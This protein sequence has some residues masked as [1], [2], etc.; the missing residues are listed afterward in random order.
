MRRRPPGPPAG[1]DGVAVGD[2][3]LNRRGGAGAPGHHLG[4]SGA[5]IMT[6]LLNHL[7]Q[8]GGRY[9]LQ[10]MCEAGGMA[11]A[12]VLERLG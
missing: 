3:I 1:R 2:A 9:G 7:E 4:D 8:T 10:T 6:T 5:G 11:N 12:T